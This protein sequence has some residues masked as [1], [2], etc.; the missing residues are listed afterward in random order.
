LIGL[1]QK[2]KVDITFALQSTIGIQRKLV[3]T[4]LLNILTT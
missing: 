3:L 4:D 1:L 2:S